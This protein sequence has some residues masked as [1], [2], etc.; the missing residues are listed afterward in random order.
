MYNTYINYRNGSNKMNINEL[1]FEPHHVGGNNTQAKH[2][3]SNG[4]GVSVVTGHLFHTTE[5]H[6]Y[7][8]AVLD[9]NGI[10]YSTPITDDV[11]GELSEDDVNRLLADVEA[12][13]PKDK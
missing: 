12:L 5:S 7:E 1:N 2:M 6:P 10:T 3:F 4:F 13:N 9:E 11:L 8:L